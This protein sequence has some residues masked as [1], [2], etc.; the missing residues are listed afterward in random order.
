M[1]QRSERTTQRKKKRCSDGGTDKWVPPTA[2]T[3]RGTH[4][5]SC[6]VD[7]TRRPNQRP[8]H[9]CVLRIGFPPTPT[10]SLYIPVPP[11]PTNYL[12][13]GP[14]PPRRSPSPSPSPYV[15]GGEAMALAFLL[16][17]LLGL[18]ALAALEAAALLWLVRRLR[19]RDSAPQPAPDADELP[20]ERPFPYEKQVRLLPLTYLSLR[21]PSSGIGDRG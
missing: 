15:F 2:E 14:Q 19:R 7:E 12:Q 13:P 16:G 1:K 10:L 20:G 18:L 3:P 6:K 5:P 11:T 8:R 21:L 4:A 9:P 17:F